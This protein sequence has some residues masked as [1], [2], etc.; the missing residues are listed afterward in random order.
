MIYPCAQ[1]TL[2]SFFNRL[3]IIFVQE[4]LLKKHLISTI[5]LVTFRHCE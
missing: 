4:I 1:L 5:D 2:L 3:R